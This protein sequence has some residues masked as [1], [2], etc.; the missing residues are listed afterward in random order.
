MRVCMYAAGGASSGLRGAQ[1]NGGSF[2]PWCCRLEAAGCDAGQS[3]QGTTE[4]RRRL[5]LVHEG[6]A[7]TDNCLKK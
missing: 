3:L 1:V 6:N 2:S 5:G 7:M 4:K